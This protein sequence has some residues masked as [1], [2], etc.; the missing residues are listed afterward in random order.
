[1]AKKTLAIGPSGLQQH[2]A[3]VAVHLHPS[4]GPCH[5]TRG[6]EI[7]AL[8]DDHV[9]SAGQFEQRYVLGLKHVPLLPQLP[10]HRSSV[11]SWVSCRPPKNSSSTMP[12]RCNSPP[13]SCLG[14]RTSFGLGLRL[15]FRLG[16]HCCH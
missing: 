7:A 8:Q 4:N 6:V 3:R 9:D 10:R 15:A 1:M 12:Q 14:L 16:R 5:L 13:C 2:V 11:S